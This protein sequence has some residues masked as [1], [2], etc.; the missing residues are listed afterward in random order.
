[1]HKTDL[2]IIPAKTR[3]IRRERQEGIK[4]KEEDTFQELLMLFKAPN[5]GG[6]LNVARKKKE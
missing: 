3:K 1:M 4:K 5:L 6:Q 2:E